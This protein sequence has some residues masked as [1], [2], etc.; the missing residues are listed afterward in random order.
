[1]PAD[2]PLT[3]GLVG[4]CGAG[5]SELARRLRRRGYRVRHIAQ[6]HSFSPTMYRRRQPPDILI[7]LH[8]TFPTTIQRK[9]FRWHER[10]YQEQL[11]RL[12][13]A[14]RHADLVIHT[15]ELTPEEV[16]AAVLEFLESEQ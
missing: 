16:E 9:G 4:V 1:M 6:E 11:R 13:H 15:D 14:R 5:K 12:E 7:Y 8:A 3:I 10:E 2:N